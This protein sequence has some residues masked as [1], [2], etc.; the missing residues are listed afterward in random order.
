MEKV[1]DEVVHCGIVGSLP[2]AFRRRPVSSYAC[3]GYLG[4]RRNHLSGTHSGL[5]KKPVP[6]C[7]WP[8]G[9]TQPVG[10]NYR[11]YGTKEEIKVMLHPSD[12]HSIL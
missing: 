7:V 4:G 9:A 11:W 12:C 10:E 3:S 6:V 1:E 2:L 8:I 5:Q